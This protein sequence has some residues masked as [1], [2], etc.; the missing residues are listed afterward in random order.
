MKV[1]QNKKSITI[2]DDLF[3]NQ[4]LEKLDS[5]FTHYTMWG[6]GHDQ[7]EYSSSLSSLCRSLKWDQWVGVHAILN[8]VCD[9][10]TERIHANTD[11]KVPYFHRCLINCFRFGDSPMFH[12]DSPNNPK[13]RTFMVYPNKVWDLNWGGYT[14]FAD[15]NNNV[16]DVANPKPG[17][18]VIFD[19]HILHSGVAPTRVHQGK[20]RFSIAYQDPE[21]TTDPSTRK[22]CKPED[23]ERTSFA[24][25]YGDKW[26]RL[27]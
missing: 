12:P 19:G 27:K 15:E 23:I 21:G 6:L 1:F 3:T 11:I 10:M 14:V 17:R 18:I 26:N 20:G 25:V 16:Y 13:G 2:I 4:E 5:W 8:D 9:I 22:R 7:K 24:S